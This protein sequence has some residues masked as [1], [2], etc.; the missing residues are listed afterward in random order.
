[1]KKLDARVAKLEQRTDDGGGEW[2][3]ISI[4]QHM[5]V[6]DLLNQCPVT[7]K[8]PSELQAARQQWKS[9]YRPRK[10]VQ[11][12]SAEAEALLR[13]TMSTSQQPV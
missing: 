10:R 4:E 11:R 6:F 3:D 1:M 12:L 8:S 13:S 9:E 2:V 5:E 7:P